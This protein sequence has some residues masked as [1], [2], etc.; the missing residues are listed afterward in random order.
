MG[1]CRRLLQRSKNNVY[2]RRAPQ[3]TH[4]EMTAWRWGSDLVGYWRHSRLDP[5]TDASALQLCTS[6]ALSGAATSSTLGCQEELQAG[7]FGGGNSALV[8]PL[9]PVLPSDND[10]ISQLI[11]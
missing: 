9:L 3:F 4:F 11:H 1:W 6:M 7:K 10:L 8:R 2:T 5:G